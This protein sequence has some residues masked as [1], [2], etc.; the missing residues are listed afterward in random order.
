[1]DAQA[2]PAWPRSFKVIGVLNIL[3]GGALLLCGTGGLWFC[4]PTLAENSPF[5]LDPV[6][7]RQIVVEMRRQMIEDARQDERN[8]S[9]NATKEHA[10]RAR[11]ELEATPENLDSKVDFQKINESLPW[12]SR[13]LWTEVITGLFLNLL[14][15]LGGLGL[16][17][18][19][20]W[21][22]KL[23]IGVAGLK[24]LRLAL[25]SLILG[26]IVVPGVRGTME[27]FAGT[28]F[29]RSMLRHAIESRNAGGIPTAQ[30][31]PAEFVQIFAAL[32]YG[33]ALMSLALGAIY[34]VICLI[35]LTR[36]KS[37]GQVPQGT[38]SA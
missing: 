35:L 20:N 9:D 19:R 23:T 34:P 28:E 7:T 31:E 30:I 38:V 22:R 10:R 26:F 29:G 32:G 37:S 6:Q 14:L 11:E 15:V 3:F 13:Y 24:I 25:L 18:G 36:P 21:G 33:Y 27:E 8:T 5:H 16:V 4:G 12:L 1:M 2:T 17:L